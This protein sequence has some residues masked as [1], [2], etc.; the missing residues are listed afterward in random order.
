MA[1]YNQPSKLEIS[2]RMHVIETAMGFVL[3]RDNDNPDLTFWDGQVAE[4]V[5]LLTG[6]AAKG[7]GAMFLHF[8]LAKTGTNRR[9]E[10][11]TAVDSSI[12]LAR[13]ELRAEGMD[14]DT[15]DADG[16]PREEGA[17]FGLAIVYF[18]HAIEWA[19]AELAN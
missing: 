5:E 9:G 4:G 6:D 17:W 3:R 2:R 12:M 10:P 1:F 8:T 14:V 19:E 11:V 7:V 16:Y 13:N 15:F 18:R